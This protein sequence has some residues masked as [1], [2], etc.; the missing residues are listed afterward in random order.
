MAPTE[1]RLMFWVTQQSEEDKHSR[2]IRGLD[3]EVSQ[4]FDAACQSCPDRL[5]EIWAESSLSDNVVQLGCLAT[6]IRTA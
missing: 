6:S 5:D 2:L 3:D 4:S 1:M